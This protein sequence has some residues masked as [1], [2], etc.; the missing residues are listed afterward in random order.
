MITFFFTFFL[1]LHLLNCPV[2]IFLWLC[3]WQL[4]F[5]WSCDLIFL[6]ASSFFLLST[7][8]AL[9]SLT[10]NMNFDTALASVVNPVVQALNANGDRMAVSM[11]VPLYGFDLVLSAA[12]V[13][14]VNSLC[15]APVAISGPYSHTH[16]P[17]TNPAGAGVVGVGATSAGSPPMGGIPMPQQ[18]P[19][20]TF[21][22]ANR[23]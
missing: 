23:Y 15:P 10:M 19:R 16:L 12:L 6:P 9:P 13:P 4:S 14:N 1:K 18:P 5:S 11:K 22:V 21:A 8:P 2:A 20:N 7:Y 17:S 3:P